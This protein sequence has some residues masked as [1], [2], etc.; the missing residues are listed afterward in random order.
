MITVQ[1]PNIF[2]LNNLLGYP[3][4]PHFLPQYCMYIFSNASSFSVFPQTP[5]PST[6]HRKFMVSYQQTPFLVSLFL[7]QL[8][9]G[10]ASKRVLPLRPS[11]VV[12]IFSPTALQPWV[13]IFD[14]YPP[15]TAKTLP[16]FFLSSVPLKTTTQSCITSHLLMSPTDLAVTSLHSGKNTTSGLMCFSL[17]YS[18]YILGDL[19]TNVHQVS[20]ILASQSLNFLTS[21]NL[22]HILSTGSRPCHR[23][24][25]KI[26][27]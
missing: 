24:T 17:T 5:K 4:S 21:K 22:F 10:Y 26:L 1:C 16:V 7:L 8:Q 19:S 2:Y 13:K 18:F 27:I 11:Q 12:A 9:L 14:P 25:S 15:T 20:Y 6:Y 3:S 23:T